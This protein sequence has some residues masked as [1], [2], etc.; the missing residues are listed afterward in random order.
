MAKPETEKAAVG[1]EAGAVLVG[2]LVEVSRV[3]FRMR[4][5]G[6]KIG[7][8]TPGGAGRW[9]L[10]RSLK[11]EGPQ[12]VPALA[13]ARPVARQHIQKLADAMLASGLI[14]RIDNPGHRRSKLLRLTAKGEST[15]A[16]I[17]SRVSAVAARIAEG[18]V[19]RELRTTARVLK[20]LSHKIGNV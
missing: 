16:A 11:Q 3:F 18:M 1:A 6:A 7:A 13:R 14:E 20:E 19:L 9:G 2:I 4:A 12:T 10:M 8:V 17:D 15:F 5:A